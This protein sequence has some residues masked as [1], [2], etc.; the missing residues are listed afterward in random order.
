MI[1]WISLET[2]RLRNSRPITITI[3][4]PTLVLLHELILA[5]AEHRPDVAAIVGVSVN[6]ITFTHATQHGAGK[7]VK[8]F[9]SQRLSGYVGYRQQPV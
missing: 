8:T 4:P 7:T 2:V 3:S 9:T 5:L 6:E 1:G